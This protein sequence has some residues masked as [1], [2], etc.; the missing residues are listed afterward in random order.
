MRG[1][2]PPLATGGGQWAGYP[3]SS[4]E[5]MHD[6]LRWT[7]VHQCCIDVPLPLATVDDPLGSRLW[8]NRDC[9]RLHPPV[10]QLAN[11]DTK[12]PGRNIGDLYTV[13]RETCV[14]FK[15]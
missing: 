5:L 12:R 1:A 11:L 6:G 14:H 7:G 10:L 8:M 15:H 9:Q 2:A 13:R 3:I 4:L